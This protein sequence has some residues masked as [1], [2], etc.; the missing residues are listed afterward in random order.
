[1]KSALAA[2]ASALFVAACTNSTPVPTNGGASEIS[3]QDDGVSGRVTFAPGSTIPAG[4][5]TKPAVGRVKLVVVTLADSPS[6]DVTSASFTAKN[7]APIPFELALEGTTIDPSRSYSVQA[8]LDVDGDG[9]V[10]TGDY[11]TVQSYPVLTHGHGSVVDV[12]L[13]AVGS[14]AATRTV[15][16]NVLLSGG[17]TNVSF[18]FAGVVRVVDVSFADA[19][20][21]TIASQT[22]DVTGPGPIPFAVPVSGIRANASY[23]VEVHLDT[24][25]NGT[26]SKG[27]FITMESFPVLTFGH[28]SVLDVT[29]E[30]L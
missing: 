9:Q 13:V 3:A 27:D 4:W 24:D 5:E 21:K 28:G 8:H 26:V 2:A 7:G 10:S 17:T 15:S 16:G 12:E 18:P 29:A 25:N 11:V 30:R 22:I 19:P 1:M 6:I 23:S 20:S 14:S